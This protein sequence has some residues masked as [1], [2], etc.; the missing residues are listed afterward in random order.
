MKLLHF[1]FQVHD[2]ERTTQA[3]RELFG[4]EWEP[5]K[6]YALPPREGEEGA[7]RTKVSHAWTDDGVEIEMVQ[8]VEGTSVD[9]AVLGDREGIS[10]VAFAVDDLAA[11]KA[12]AQANGLKVIHEGTAPRASWFFI[13]DDR[14][15]GALIQM[16]Q[17]HEQPAA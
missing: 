8:Q 15:G 3:Y 9:H 6:E 1:G 10:H 16:V 5:V 2:I 17:L 11:E 12:K 7:S 4:L 13:Q 14:L